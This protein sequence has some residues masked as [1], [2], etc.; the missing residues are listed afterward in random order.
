MKE[1]LSI[2]LL[3]LFSFVG[4]AQSDSLIGT[5]KVSKYAD[6][7]YVKASVDWKISQK[8]VNSDFSFTSFYK[9]NKKTTVM[10]PQANN[11]LVVLAPS[12]EEEA[13]DFDFAK[14]FQS[15]PFT[16]QIKLRNGES[17]AVTIYFTVSKFG[18]IRFADAVPVEKLGDTIV[19]YTNGMKEKYKIDVAHVK[20]KKAFAALASSRWRAAKIKEL[21]KHP[22]KRRIKY[23]KYRGFTEGTL[24]VNYSSVPF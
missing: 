19:V 8:S 18:R 12:P 17:E 9:I 5:I 11:L 23:K 16:K 3:F 20:T 14:Y 10:Q 22:S 6:S 1:L 2:I 24:T 7:V 21:K 15:N 4:A 13:V